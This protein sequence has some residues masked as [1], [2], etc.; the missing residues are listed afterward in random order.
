MDILRNVAAVEEKRRAKT[1]RRQS[2]EGMA[3]YRD[4]CDRTKKAARSDKQN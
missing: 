3:A 2:T 4:L 1:K